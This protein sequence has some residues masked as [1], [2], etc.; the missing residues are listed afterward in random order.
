VDLAA[1]V[2]G[3]DLR[4][5]N[6]EL[7]E[8]AVAVAEADA[9]N[10]VGARTQWETANPPGPGAEIRAP[11]GIVRYE[12][13]DLTVTVG[14]GTTF[15]DLDAALG[16]QGQ[17]CA[18]DP[19]DPSATVGGI[20]ACGLSGIRRL[21]HGPLRDHVLEVRFL[22]GDGRIVK[23]GGPTVKNVTG[24][25]LPRLFVGSF[26][27]LGVIVQLTLRCRPRA[28]HAGWFRTDAPVDRFRA[29]AMLW[30]GREVFVRLEGVPADV[31]TQA[32]GLE[33]CAAPTL[34]DGAHRGR[35]SVAPGTVE[36]VGRAL[37]AVPAARWCAELGIGT[38]HVAA[39][40][41]AGLA[42]ART[43][44]HA[45]DG[46]M[47]R[48]AGGAGLDGFGRALPN[49]GLMRRV[50]DAFDPTGKLAPGRLPL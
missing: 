1:G 45:H 39:D 4:V 19:R 5:I 24:Y 34:P 25:D 9:V 8:V 38:V 14:A 31:E 36:A 47:L 46:W 28:A 16:A 41:A 35:I 44:A 13:D 30:D 7:E 40:N 2:G 43:I 42:S 6:T 21:R 27:T 11:A 10:P 17:E 32:A 23:G 49:A 15:A 20:V 12:P 48:E 3:P 22:T 50:K 33:A 18:L 29:A 37:D 26:G